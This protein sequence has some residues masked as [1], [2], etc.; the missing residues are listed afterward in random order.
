MVYQT[1]SAPRLTYTTVVE[2]TAR[3]P[4]SQPVNEP[5]KVN[6]VKKVQD[7]LWPKLQRVLAEIS[8]LEVEEITRTDSLAD[9]G[10]DSLMALELARDIENEFACTLEQSQLVSI[11]D[12]PGIL[13]LLQST[14]GLEDTGTSSSHSSGTTSSQNITPASASSGGSSPSSTLST[15]DKSSDADL[16][17][18]SSAVIEAFRA[19]KERT[20]FFLKSQ[21]CAG[22]LDGVY[23]RQVRLCLVLTK[24]AFQQ[25]G[26][27]LEAARPGDVL[28][29]VPFVA[30]HRRF[31]EYL[32][33]MLEDTRIIDIDDGGVIR[34]TGLPLPSQS[35]DEIMEGLM[36]N[37]RGN[38]SSHQ[39][40]Y[41]VGS[42][43][44]D[45]LAG[46]ADGPAL[47]FGD[48]KNRELAAHFYGE[49]PFNKV[50]IQQMGNFL[51]GLASKLGL[52]SQSSLGIPLRIMEM[53]AGT[54]GT[55][56]V[57]VPMLAELG[58][59]VEYTFTDLSPS[60][61]AQAK[62]KFK[63]YPFMRFAVHDIEQ[64]PAPELMG[65]QHIVIATNAVHATHS[66]EVSTTNIRKFLR[67]DGF[68]MLLEMMGTLHW[69]DV[70][71]GTLEGWWLFDDGRT[72]AIVD[73]KR[74]EQSLVR[75]GFKHVE[76]TDGHLPEARVQRF[77][78][79]LAA[80]LERGVAEQ[81]NLPLP[82]EEDE[83][84]HQE[85]IKGRKAAADK[86][87]ASATQGFAVPDPSQV[88]PGIPL[89]DDLSHS[90][91]QCVLITGGTGS[92][93]SHI[94]AH[95]ASLPTIRKV[96]C[97]NRTRPTRRDEQPI[98]A[99]RRQM[100]A[101]KSKSIE[102]DASMLAKLEIIETDSSQPQL[103]LDMDQYSRLVAQVTHIIHNGFPVN[104]LLP[105]E[106]NEPQFAI[107]RNLVDFAAA[108]WAG[109][110]AR[111][112]DFKCTFQL[113]SSLSAVGKYVSVSD[114]SRQVPEAPMG[115]EVSLPNGYGGAKIICER[116]L[117]D[118][119]CRHP[120]RFRAMTVRLGQVSGSARTGY[121]NHIEVLAFL[122]KSAQTLRVFPD[123]KGVLNW[124]TLED[125]S[126]A[127]AEL[128]L[129]GGDDCYTVYHLD[130]PVPRAWADL[131]PV[132]A[133]ALG[134]PRG[135]KGIVSLEEWRRRAAEFPGEDVWDNPAAKAQDF[136]EHKF[137]LMSCG[138]VTMATERARE[139]SETL[140]AAQPVS[141]EVVR[142]Y[143]DAW[144]VTGFLR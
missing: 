100:E 46:K 81:K 117:N 12:I 43:M 142:K 75:G 80:D 74:W 109:R 4:D 69:V 85:Y 67:P 49:F 2:N 65:S 96:Y 16:S 118:T 20:D 14:L 121:W 59:P 98:S 17:L 137:E 111:G 64:P 133:E 141:D 122:F 110:K 82:P 1:T 135:P 6:N 54:G 136:F 50:Y 63:Q 42:R 83:H 116:I 58:I 66:I 105:L 40:I 86:Y 44:A 56:R 99:Q 94:V 60:L 143:I 101:F 103:G 68:L 11:F 47:I 127:L 88:V 28:D 27:D 91:G 79:A 95:L 22:Y 39:L 38:E 125:A 29:P 15:I 10:I 97:L 134:V 126:T 13:N 89:P 8:G 140:R 129:R 45:V 51:T 128:L 9:V 26:C 30:R 72:H 139:H 3:Q 76:W 21:G 123:V 115:I 84:D 70:V 104:G 32:Y 37:P 71:W 35:A 93:G 102:L 92:L 144:K 25:L 7:D 73:E 113:L 48:A 130:N 18:P 106:Q 77:V 23:Q 5:P 19:S 131:V 31:H 61:V 41:N 52:S 53:G 114:G 132:L 90:S 119:L 24:Q 62:K 33:K 34:R 108:I 87:V 107:M 120:D 55:T 138:G 57:L 78:I 124:L 112:M 36:R